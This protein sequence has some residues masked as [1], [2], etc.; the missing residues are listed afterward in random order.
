MVGYSWIRQDKIMIQKS[1]LAHAEN[2]VHAPPGGTIAPRGSGLR[3]QLG[4]VFWRS[5]EAQ[6]GIEINKPSDIWS[7][8]ILVGTPYNLSDSVSRALVLD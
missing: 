4:N 1:Q 5:P 8:G 7:F 2:S 6:F 3:A